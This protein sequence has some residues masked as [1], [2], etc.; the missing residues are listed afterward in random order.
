MNKNKV[1]ALA[2]DLINVIN[3]NSAMDSE[4]KWKTRFFC[5]D[6][7]GLTLLDDIADLFESIIRSILQEESLG[8]KFSEKFIETRLLKVIKQCVENGLNEENT[9]T[10]LNNAILELEAFDTEYVVIIPVDGIKVVDLRELVLGQVRLFEMREETASNYF[11]IIEK[12]ILGTRNT[13]EEQ[14]VLIERQREKFKALIGSICSEY[15]VVAEPERAIERAEQQTKLA[16]EILGFGISLFYPDNLNIKIG[17]KGE[18]Y[19]DWRYVPIISDKNCTI[20]QH[21]VGPRSSFELKREHIEHL[22]KFRVLSFSDILKKRCPNEFELAL[23]KSLYWFNS[24]IYQNDLENK[25]LNLIT[26]IETLL[27]PRDGNPIGSAIA[28]GIAIIL[29]K[30]VENRRKLKKEVQRLYKMRSAVSHGGIKEILDADYKT[31]IRI[32]LS[33][34]IEILNMENHFNSQTD[35]LSWI[36]EQ[37]FR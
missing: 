23:L 6:G 30:G 36:E 2:K 22:D 18:I 14:Q 4:G 1:K 8:E 20:K 32:V 16:L 31:L 17:L 35:L 9:I 3:G 27:T 37:K 28:E 25:F 21:L 13:K 11:N 29:T 24:S 7:I 34:I 33:L 19:K 5:H 15:K 12:V 26:A 10:Y